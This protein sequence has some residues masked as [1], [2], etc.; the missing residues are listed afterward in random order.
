[1]CWAKGC[2]SNLFV[3]PVVQQK[4]EQVANIEYL[5]S[6]QNIDADQAG[7]V[8]FLIGDACLLLLNPSHILFKGV[9]VFVNKKQG[10]IHVAII[11]AQAPPPPLAPQNDKKNRIIT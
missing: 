9:L 3:H 1:M 7:C 2:E 10:R 4:M 8:P 5:Q 6:V 11:P